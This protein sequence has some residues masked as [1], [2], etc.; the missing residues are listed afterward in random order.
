MHLGLAVPYPG[1]TDIWDNPYLIQVSK[2][3][4]IGHAQFII[5]DELFLIQRTH[6][7]S[8]IPNPGTV[9]IRDDLYWPTELSP[10]MLLGE[11]PLT[12]HVE[13]QI[14]TVDVL[15]DKEEPG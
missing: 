5:W 11:F 8:A 9:H 4:W 15:N 3:S 7:G 2:G 14:S 1:T 6:Q 10:G 12:L 13:H